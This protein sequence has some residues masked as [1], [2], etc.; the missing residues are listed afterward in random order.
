MTLVRERRRAHRNPHFLGWHVAS[1]L[2][3][4]SLS[5]LQAE[6]KS[7]F[8]EVPKS[9]GLAREQHRSFVC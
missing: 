4:V 6:H 8:Q 5:Q 2:F 9:L 1:V 7:Q 3:R